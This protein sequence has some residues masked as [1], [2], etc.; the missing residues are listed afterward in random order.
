MCQSIVNT[1][2]SAQRR[3]CKQHLVALVLFFPDLIVRQSHQ[4]HQRNSDGWGW[5][6]EGGCNYSSLQSEITFLPWYLIFF[7]QAVFQISLFIDFLQFDSDVSR[8]VFLFIILLGVTW[9]SSICGLIVSL[10]QKNFSRY[11][12]NFFFLPVYPSLF[13][14]ELPLYEI[15]FDIIP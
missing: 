10:V 11:F 12:Y 15:L 5:G 1:F 8:S 6:G 13:L 4:P 9:N 3:I 2:P 7:P 14:Q